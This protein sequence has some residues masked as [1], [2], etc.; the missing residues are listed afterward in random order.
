MPTAQILVEGWRAAGATHVS[1]NTMGA[2]FR[3][4]EE[5]LAAVR[6]FAKT[7]LP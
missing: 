2:G 4:A 7:L 3:T 5:H 6:R 1:L